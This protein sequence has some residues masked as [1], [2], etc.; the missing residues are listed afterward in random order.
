MMVT[1]VMAHARL[2]VFLF[3]NFVCPINTSVAS[4]ASALVKHLPLQS[5]RHFCPKWSLFV[6]ASVYTH[7]EKGKSRFDWLL[8]NGIAMIKALKSAFDKQ[9][10]GSH[11]KIGFDRKKGFPPHLHLRCVVGGQPLGRAWS[12]VRFREGLEV[13]AVI[14][15]KQ[16]NLEN[17][18]RCLEQVKVPFRLLHQPWAVS[19]KAFVL[20]SKW[21]LGPSASYLRNAII[22]SYCLP[23]SRLDFPKKCTFIS[24]WKLWKWFQF[25]ILRDF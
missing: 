2:F 1:R 3:T 10:A 21:S 5:Q 24:L 22:R 19:L 13:W 9:E 23:Y 17:Q 11:Q 8:N 16:T 12:E 6:N 14:R 4:C 7:T 20:Y 25:G 18:S 15:W